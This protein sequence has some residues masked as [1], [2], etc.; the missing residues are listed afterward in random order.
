MM[1]VINHEMAMFE[2]VWKAGNR[3]RGEGGREGNLPCIYDGFYNT[4]IY[5]Y[6]NNRHISL[7]YYGR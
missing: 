3:E 7:N 4:D 5:I 2:T 6:T 1:T